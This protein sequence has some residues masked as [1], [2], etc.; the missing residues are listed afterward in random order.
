M[1]LLNQF[2]RVAAVALSVMAASFA[3]ARPVPTGT[4]FTYQGQLKQ[5]GNNASGTYDLQLSLWD[6]SA[7]PTQIGSTIC[8]DN[9]AVTDGLFTIS[10]DFGAGV[11]G[12]EAR[13]LEIGVRSDNTAGNCNGGAYTTLAPRQRLTATPVSL[14]ALGADGPNITNLN[15]SNLA[16][17]TVPN[18]V[19]S[20]AYGNAVS[21]TNAGNTFAGS[22]AGLTGLSAANISTGLLPVARGGTGAGTAPTALAN[23]NAQAR[24]TGAAPAGSYITAINVDGSVVTALDQNSGGDIT[25]VTAGAGL[26]GGGLSGAVSLNIAANGVTNA[27]L[28]NDQLSL[29]KVSGGAMSSSGGEIGIGTLTP[30][31]LLDVVRT[32]PSNNINPVAVFRTAGA[33]SSV[34]AI[35]LQNSLGNHFNIGTTAANQFALN[36]NANIAQA[37][38]LLRITSTGNVG[39][40]TLSP[41]S[42]LDVG[43]NA[44]VSGLL[45]VDGNLALDGNLNMLAGQSILANGALTIG[46]A[47]LDIHLGDSSADETYVHTPL[48]FK[49]T[50]DRTTI[51]M[52]GDVGG[53]SRIEFFSDLN[54]TTAA[55]FL[56][57]D[58][59]NNGRILIREDGGTNRAVLEVEGT[60][61]SEGA[62]LVLYNNTGVAT[63]ELDANWAGTGDG[64]IVTQ[65]LQI[66]G[67][68]DLSEQFNVNATAS[69]LQPGMLVCI[70]PRNIGELV[71][72]RKAYDRT[73]AGIIS[74]AGGVKTGM[75]MGQKGT[76][77]DGQHPVA[78]TGRVYCW[79]DASTGAIKPGD[80]LTTSNV[81][82]HAMK[83][84]DHNRANGA[85]IGKAMSSLD[86]G[87]GLVLVLVSLQ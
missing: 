51:L 45:D 64:R 79:C 69:D 13:W 35:R 80:L 48:I 24:V 61:T 47:N 33:T 46:G 53:E 36:Y 25:A 39:I 27:M 70:D 40:G 1:K 55:L 6:A 82:G 16:T 54:A 57:V 67:G 26:G 50:T 21:F 85:I 63:I 62:Q 73:V 59:N 10:V 66:T 75:M 34:G 83:V 74:G 31:N 14:F 28:A 77:A 3:M 49:T 76:E 17:G 9:V 20:G 2:V 11:F 65:E 44:H 60:G 72:S 22:G 7:G 52:D 87:K 4:A 18:A 56:D 37:T 15:A 32:P 23:L 43:G 29:N 81:P 86:E 41:T 38:D 12:T 58:G 84:K 5:G 42:R 71:I 30:S 19:I 78:L 68:S 8:V